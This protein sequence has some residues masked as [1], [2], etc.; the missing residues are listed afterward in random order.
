MFANHQAAI[1]L[2]IEKST[3]RMC[4]ILAICVELALVTDGLRL[5]LAS[6]S[7][8]ITEMQCLRD[9]LSDWR[10]VV[11][12]RLQEKYGCIIHERGLMNEK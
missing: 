11:V 10:M 1:A 7:P 2:L 4:D 8:T 12:F 5:K 6:H 9:Q 3:G